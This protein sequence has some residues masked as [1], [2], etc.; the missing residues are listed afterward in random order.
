MPPRGILCALG[1]KKKKEEIKKK[2]VKPEIGQCG[3]GMP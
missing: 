2:K 3:I 1:D